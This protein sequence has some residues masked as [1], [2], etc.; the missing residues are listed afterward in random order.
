MILKKFYFP[1]DVGWGW[2]FLYLKIKELYI[3]Q[4]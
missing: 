1:G 3:M 4:L 2:V